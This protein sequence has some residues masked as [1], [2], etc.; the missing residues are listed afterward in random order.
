M[1]FELNRSAKIPTWKITAA[2][3]MAAMISKVCEH[4]RRDPRAGDEWHLSLTATA[5]NCDL[6]DM[7][8]MKF[9]VNISDQDRKYIADKLHEAKE[10]EET[11][12]RMLV[13][14]KETSPDMEIPLEITLY[15]TQREA[16]N[17]VSSLKR[18]LIADPMG[19]GKTAMGVGVA[20]RPGGLPALVI[21]PV[22]LMHQWEL[23]IK[24][25]CPLMITHRLRGTRPYDP[26]PAD[27][28]I[29]AYT[30][31]SGW[32][33]WLVDQDF[34][35]VILDE[36]HN[37][38]RE[39]TAKHTAA[40]I[41]SEGCEG[42]V[43]GLSGSPIYNY[44]DDIYHVIDVVNPGYLG[45]W[46]DFAHDWCAG[47]FGRMAKIIKDPHLL[48]E[49]LRNEG[50]MIRRSYEELGMKAGNPIIEMVTIDASIEELQKIEA[51][52]IKLAQKTLTASFEEAGTAAREFNTKLRHATGCAKVV[53]AAEF[54]EDLLDQEVQKV[55]VVAHHHDVYNGLRKRLDKYGVVEYTGRVNAI[56][57]ATEVR[58]FIYGP[59]KILL[60]SVLAGEGLD[61]LQTVCNHMVFVELDWSPSRHAQ[62][63][64]RLDRPGQKLPVYVNFLVID[65]GSDPPVVNMLGMKRTMRDGVVDLVPA[66]LVPDDMPTS[67]VLDMATAYLDQKKRSVFEGSNASP[68]ELGAKVSTL[69]TA[70]KLPVASSEA[71]LGDIVEKILRKEFGD[72][73]EREHKLDDNNRIDFK[74]DG[75]G[76]ELKIQGA[77][78]EV[79]RQLVRYSEH[80]KELVLVCPWPLQN[81]AVGNTYCHVVC[82]TRKS[83]N[84]T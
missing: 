28:Y 16:V 34:K 62:V 57:K 37:V 65:D 78:S 6:L 13:E 9:K 5:R 44:A 52:A 40:R 77:R 2:P 74:V 63:I 3:K 80:L 27:Y 26:G 61:G 60:M 82:Y 46:N 43:V 23:K 41:I 58:R 30:R 72:R 15:P 36:V 45:S 55:V 54:V 32:L 8:V 79:Y 24:E 21:C 73:V 19:A 18:L 50:L 69:L 48:G 47:S 22:H 64:G 70:A 39:D 83:E 4:A 25:Y 56:S 17:L 10:R 67:R 11:V 71:E 14:A 31:I 49:H 84:L 66:D 76:V 38:R 81:M 42:A 59:C 35:T 75:V 7:F 29:T 20:S 33:K 51:H 1:K 12:K 53:A 68:T